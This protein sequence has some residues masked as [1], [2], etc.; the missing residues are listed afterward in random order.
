MDVL[1][2]A[3]AAVRISVPY[4]LAAMGASLSERGGVVCIALEG[5]MLNGALAYTLGA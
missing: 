1:L 3:A 2:F 4:A 5:L